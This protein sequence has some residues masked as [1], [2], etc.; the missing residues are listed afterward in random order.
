MNAL[1]LKEMLAAG[2]V[3]IEFKECAEDLEAYVEP[4]MRAHVISVKVGPDDIA[5]LK[6]DYS[7]YD[8]FNKAFETANY[9][10]KNGNPTLT[11]RESGDYNLQE[12]LYVSASEELDPILTALPSVSAHLLDEYRASGQSSYVR[13]LEEQL[14]AARTVGSQ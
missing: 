2:P 3:A 14:V 6:V 1:D 7:A 5:V 10:D 8:E 9:F 13:W 4:K 12:D 11:A